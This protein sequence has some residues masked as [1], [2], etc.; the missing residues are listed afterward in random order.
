VKKSGIAP[1]AM[2]LILDVKL[3]ESEKNDFNIVL[4]NAKGEE[5]RVGY[6]AQINAYYSNRTKAGKIEFAEKFANKVSIAPRVSTSK[7]LKMHLFFDVASCE[8]FADD[9]RVILTD[10]FFPN[11][12]FTEMRIEGVGALSGEI[13][14]L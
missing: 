1:S 7:N 4:S 2:E 14:G 3:S 6:D 9:G 10:I 11:G 13:Y 8:L 5:F 12:D